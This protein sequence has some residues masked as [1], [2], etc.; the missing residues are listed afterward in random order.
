MDC[1]YIAVLRGATRQAARP[2]L[3]VRDP[4]LVA[5]LG[6]AIADRLGVDLDIGTVETPARERG[7]GR[8]VT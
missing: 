5:L 2:I 7:S 3:V 4:E 8:V 1:L 6:A